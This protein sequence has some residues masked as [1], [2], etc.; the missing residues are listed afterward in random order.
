[1][2]KWSPNPVLPEHP[3]L[4]LKSKK[5][6][7]LPWLA[8]NV[9]AEGLYPAAEFVSDPNHLQEFN[10]RWDELLPFILDFNYTVDAS[11][12][13]DILK[14]IRAEYLKDKPVNKDTFLQ[15]VDVR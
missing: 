7:D 10:A 1:M 14:K 3:Y 11:D 13:A 12:R 6:Q 4:L 5:V 9:Q 8:S 15:V 2:D